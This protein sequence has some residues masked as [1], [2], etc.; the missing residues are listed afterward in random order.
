[1]TYSRQTAAAIVRRFEEFVRA[2]EMRGALHPDDRAEIHA[3]YLKA[4]ARLIEAL[5]S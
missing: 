2:D 4:R 1:M 3:R 5:V